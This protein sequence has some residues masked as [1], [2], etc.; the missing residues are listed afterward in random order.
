[1]YAMI[2][3]NRKLRVADSGV[4]RGSPSFSTFTLEDAERA[5]AA[6]IASRPADIKEDAE[7]GEARQAENVQ[8]ASAS[9]QSTKKQVQRSKKKAEDEEAANHEEDHHHLHECH[10]HDG[11]DVCDPDSDSEEAFEAALDDLPEDEAALREK[12]EHLFAGLGKIELGGKRVDVLNQGGTLGQNSF[13]GSIDDAAKAKGVPKSQYID[14]IVANS[15]GMEG[16]EVQ[17]A[18]NAVVSKLVALGHA[19]Q[20]QISFAKREVERAVSEWLAAQ[21][22]ARRLA[23][24]LRAKLRAS[25]RQAKYKCGVCGRPWGGCSGC[26]TYMGPVFDGY[27]EASRDQ[28]E[29]AAQQVEAAQKI[30]GL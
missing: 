30:E 3:R 6:F 20:E 11:K 25:M 15:L 29:A 10:S 5:V 17:S 27:T 9:S 2:E 18:I 19:S 12:F 7:E 24:L 23:Q 8:T 1:M 14:E 28:V 13:E 26:C 22:E 21:K 4:L 16:L